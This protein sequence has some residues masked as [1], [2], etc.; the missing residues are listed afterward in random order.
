MFLFINAYILSI[1]VS[2][3]MGKNIN[4]FQIGD[5]VILNFHLVRVVINLGNLFQNNT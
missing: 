5:V 2:S 3:F 1:I 4:W